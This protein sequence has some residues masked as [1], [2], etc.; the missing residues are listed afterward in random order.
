MFEL[1]GA[2]DTWRMELARERT[3]APDALDELEDHVRA[4]FAAHVAA[5]MEP[6]AAFAAAQDRLGRPAALC[7]EFMK[8]ESSVWRRLMVVGWAL[9]A[10]AFFMPVESYDLALFNLRWGGGAVL[11]Y[12]AFVLALRGEAGTVG[13]LSALTN[14]LVLASVW[15]WPTSR[16][17]L[18]LASSVMIFGAAV[19][20]AWW[21]ISVE[22]I[23]DLHVG[24]Y[25]WLSSFVIVGGG[26]A[27]RARQV[28]LKERVALA[29]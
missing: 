22:A 8:V 20:N 16:R 11:G 12:D 17:R 6:G 25:M 18:V 7:G 23:R 5:G 28:A 24:Y 3:L 15:W 29:A 13:V 19:L 21:L 4:A 26:L 10:V 9:F 14:F 1:E 2:I 27:M